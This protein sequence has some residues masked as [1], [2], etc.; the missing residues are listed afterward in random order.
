M[1]FQS[2]EAK[3]IGQKAV[4][5]NRDR[6]FEPFRKGRGK[7]RGHFIE[8]HNQ[9]RVFSFHGAWTNAERM[10][11]AGHRMRGPFGHRP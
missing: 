6:A 9:G 7:G 11:I 2:V 1:P 10:P 3:T 5:L 4:G 8:V